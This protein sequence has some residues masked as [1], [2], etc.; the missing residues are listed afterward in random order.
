MA[1]PQPHPARGAQRL[2]L[3]RLEQWRYLGYGMFIHFGMSTFLGEELPHGRHGASTYAPDALDVDQW[4][5]VARDA[6]MTYAVLTTKHVAGHCL[7][8]SDHTDYH[9]GHSAETTDVVAAFTD[10]CRRHG[11]M[12][13][14]YYC[15]WDN[16]HR[17]GSVTPTDTHLRWGEELGFRRNTRHQHEAYTTAAYRDFQLRQIEELL[18]RYGPIGEMWVDIPGVLGPEGRREL[19]DHIVSFND[20]IVIMM[21]HGLSDGLTFDPNYAWPTDLMAIE[22]NLPAARGKHGRA[23]GWYRLKL[24]GGERR[25]YWIPAEVCDTIGQAWFH[26][27]ADTPRSDAEL[28]G[29]HLLCQGRGAN[30]LLNVPPDRSGRIPQRCVDALHR[31]RNVERSALGPHR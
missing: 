12:P 17:F 27:D 31:L 15:C 14:L 19:Y 2:P 26:E 7:W 9:V 11:L 1:T 22:R 3:D 13:G 16:H 20:D 18:T 5:A 6:G 21:N 29:M 28:A 4:I 10:A 30:L 25:D 24:D 8:P 23:D